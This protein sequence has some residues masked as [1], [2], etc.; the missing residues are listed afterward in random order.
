MEERL[1]TRPQVEFLAGVSRSTIYAWMQRGEFPRP[2]KLGTR[3]VRWRLSDID[4]WVKAR[5]TKAG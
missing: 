3:L 4:A 1:L 5:E 2:V